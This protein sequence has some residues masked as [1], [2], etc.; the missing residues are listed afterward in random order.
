MVGAPWLILAML[1]I[2]GLVA[3]LSI[4]QVSEPD[5]GFHLAAGHYVLEGRGWPKTDPFSFTYTDHEYID[6]QWGYQVLL[7]LTEQAA[8]PAGMTALNGILILWTFFLLYRT[9]SLRS[10]GPVSLLLL[11][12]LAVLAS[13][14]RFAVRPE[15][16]TWL[17]LAG[18][19]HLLYRRELELNAHLWLLPAIQVLWVNCHSGFVLGWA[20][21][22]CFL[23]GQYFRLGRWDRRVAVWAVAAVLVGLINPYH[24]RGVVFPFELLTR[25][26]SGNPF[27][28]AI[29]ELISPFAVVSQTTTQ[30]PFFPA[31]ILVSFFILF[32]LALIA[33][34]LLALKRRYWLVLWFIPVLVLSAGTMR[35]MPL[36]AV[37]GLPAM[38][39]V[40]PTR[41]ASVWLGNRISGRKRLLIAAPAVILT[42]LVLSANVITD[43]HYLRTR[44]PDRFGWGWNADVLPVAAA[45][46]VHRNDLP[47]RMLNHLNFG[48]YLIWAT[49]Y[50]VFIDGR[51]EVLGE[52]FF[53]EY[54]Q[55]LAPRLDKKE[56]LK[57]LNAA[58]DKWGINWI[59]FP[60]ILNPPLL[61]LLSHAP[62]WR[63]LYFDQTAVIFY[64]QDKEMEYI[65]GIVAPIPPTPPVLLPLTDLPGLNGR[66]RPG[67]I[68]RFISGATEKQHYPTR[69]QMLGLFHYFRGDLNEALACFS[70]AIRESRGQYYELYHNMG[71]VLYR[72]GR[73][74]EAAMCYR[75]VLA[76]KPGH[77]L[78][79]RRLD[80][81]TK[82]AD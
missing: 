60:Y 39:Q 72:M 57:N 55:Y 67:F 56:W 76:D 25:F 71:T 1:L 30:F 28:Q 24:F 75:V 61:N 21:M 13:E 23:V 2:F 68:S 3:L 79:L 26:S 20:A 45:D 10:L 62:N 64:R 78:A 41:R 81:I 53:L 49:G 5:A 22:A 17:F 33:G 29:G 44:R 38:L 42:T 46:F 9:G 80:K 27:N 11:F 50:P 40:L 31:S 35:N 48:G 51:L 58:A 8:G 7:A 4:R 70:S 19:L 43:A 54:N 32:T 52:E 36:L 15:I 14:H 59:I 69:S 73:L 12:L 74:E 65:P 63:L 66:P 18:T 82:Q 47:G 34:V 6:S 37:G 16:M 77:A